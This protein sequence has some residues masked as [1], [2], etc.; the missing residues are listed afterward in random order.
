M[1]FRCIICVC[2]PA[3]TLINVGSLKKRLNDVFEMGGLFNRIGNPS[4]IPK[5]LI[6]IDSHNMLGFDEL[7]FLFFFFLPQSLNQSQ[8]KRKKRK[9]RK[10]KK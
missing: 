7:F 3:C 1:I 4:L 5:P 2:L 6:W 9:K 10:S 8:K